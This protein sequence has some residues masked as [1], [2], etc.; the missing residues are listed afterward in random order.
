MKWRLRLLIVLSGGIAHCSN[1]NMEQ[2]NCKWRHFNALCHFFFWCG[3]SLFSFFLPSPAMGHHFHISVDLFIS[4]PSYLP[5]HYCDISAF[6]IF[7]FIFF[8]FASHPI[9]RCLYCIFCSFSAICSTLP[10]LIMFIFIYFFALSLSLTESCSLWCVSRA[11]FVLNLWKFMQ[12]AS[13][14]LLHYW[15]KL[16][17]ILGS[18]LRMPMASG[19][20]F[21]C[22][23]PRIDSQTTTRAVN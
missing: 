12:H 15:M 21:L 6:P 16:L 1:A 14:Y 7:I 13:A 23:N 8:Y 2:A 5:G 9:Y 4:F 19:C 20:S 22:N 17:V 18:Y 3:L 11:V 10:S